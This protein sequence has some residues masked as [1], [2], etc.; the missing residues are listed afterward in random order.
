MA[1]VK[2]KPAAAEIEDSIPT[3]PALDDEAAFDDDAPVAA[4]IESSTPVLDALT[5]A[6]P[7]VVASELEPEPL[8]AVLEV[9]PTRSALRAGAQPKATYIVWS[10]GSL[11]RN[12]VAYGPGD[13]VELT[14]AEA[15][16][17]GPCVSP[18]K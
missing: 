15:A 8:P 16:A 18:T 10:H 13:S 4:G 1:S 11:Q 17:I 3:T 5:Q 12:G 9:I 14:A 6:T 2:K 7:D